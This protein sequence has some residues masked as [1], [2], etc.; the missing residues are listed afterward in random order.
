MRDRNKHWTACVYPSLFNWDP[1]AQPP[2]AKDPH[3]TADGQ[4]HFAAQP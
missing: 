4:E 1:D 2:S 3:S